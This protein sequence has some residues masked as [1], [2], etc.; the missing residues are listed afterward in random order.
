VT[1]ELTRQYNNRGKYNVKITPTVKP[2]DR[3]RVDDH[4]HGRRRQGRAIKHVNIVGNR[5]VQ[6]RGDPRRL[7]IG[8]HQLAVLVQPRRPVF[9]REAFRRPGKAQRAYYLDRGYVDFNVE[10]TQ[11]SIS[12]D[13]KDMFIT[14]NVRE[15]EIY[16]LSEVKLTGDTM[17][18][19]EELAEAGD[20]EARRYLL[21]PK[22]EPPRAM[23]AVLGNV[24]Y[25]FANVTPVPKSTARSATVEITFYVDPGKRVYVRRINFKG[26]TRTPDEVLRREMRQFE[27][28]L[29]LAGGI[30]RS[31]V[32]LQRLGY[33]KRGQHRDAEGAGQRRPGRRRGRR[34]GNHAR[35]ASVR[36]RLLAALRA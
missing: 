5:V 9:A 24:G 35:A 22:L 1:Q 27:G 29:V 11:V 14:A 34:Q 16:T 19:Q 8:H 15:G 12:P 6:R 33:F 25:A 23:I 36:P 10:S 28:Q 31:K 32:R 21:A 20:R 7:R 30:D 4:D 13:R 18:P 17:V 3:N 26:N 2:L